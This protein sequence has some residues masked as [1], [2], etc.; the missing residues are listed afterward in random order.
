MEVQEYLENKQVS[1]DQGWLPHQD[2][3]SRY[4]YVL[5]APDIF[6]L[7]LLTPTYLAVKVVQLFY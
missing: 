7:A 5:M 6:I 1:D 4:F 2:Q 3:R